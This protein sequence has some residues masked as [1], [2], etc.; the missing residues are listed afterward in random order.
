MVAVKTHSRLEVVKGGTKRTKSAQAECA[1]DESRS[2]LCSTVDFA[3]H[4]A[5]RQHTD[6]SGGIVGLGQQSTV[7]GRR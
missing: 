7:V 1:R 3:I 2:Y 6:G 4:D 5:A